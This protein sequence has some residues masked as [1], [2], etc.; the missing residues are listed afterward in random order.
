MVSFVC[1]GEAL[2]E[3]FKQY[4]IGVVSLV[5]LAIQAVR[6]FSRKFEYQIS[7]LKGNRA[8]VGAKLLFLKVSMILEEAK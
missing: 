8:N 6:A 4:L 2:L 7:C 1:Q 5:L 3:V